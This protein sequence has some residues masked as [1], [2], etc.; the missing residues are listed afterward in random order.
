MK[1]GIL[2]SSLAAV[3]ILGAIQGTSIGRPAGAL[4]APPPF[5]QAEIYLEFN[6]TDEDIGVHIDTDHGTGLREVTVVSPQGREIVDQDWST[7]RP[8]GLTEMKTESAEPDMTSALA[9]YPPGIYRISG[10]TITGQR[11]FSRARLS[12]SLLDAPEITNPAEGATGVPTVGLVVS[13]EP[14]AGARGYLIE[15]D[16]ASGKKL[17]AALPATMTSFAIPDGMLDPHAVHKV[18]VAVIAANGNR[19]LAEVEFETSG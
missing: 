9:A 18:G 19:S 10:V 2:V 15:F 11:L 7:P 14:V 5:T 16:G 4:P 12:H 8:L 17:E 13:W 1:R 6:S 3:A